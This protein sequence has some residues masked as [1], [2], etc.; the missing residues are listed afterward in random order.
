MK[1]VVLFLVAVCCC[2]LGIGANIEQNQLD[3]VLK[4]LDAVKREQLNNTKKLSSPPNDIEEHCC[5][6]ALKCFQV[7]LKGHFNATNKNIFRLEKSLRKIDTI[8]SRNFSNSGNNTTTCHACNSHPEV[9][10]Q[11]FLNRLRSLIER[12]RS[13]L[14]MK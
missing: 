2:A 10:V 9:S 12:A 13:K 1:L 7:N 5:P 8:F 6:S 4:I 14:T 11:E 3:E